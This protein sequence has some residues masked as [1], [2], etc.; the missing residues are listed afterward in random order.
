[1][2]LAL[3]TRLELTTVTHSGQLLMFVNRNWNG[4]EAG[5]VT[6][7]EAMCMKMR[8]MSETATTDQ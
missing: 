7:G 4:A 8:Q 6:T 2:G 5:T 3:L 1:M